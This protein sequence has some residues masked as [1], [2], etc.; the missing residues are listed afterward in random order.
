MEKFIHEDLFSAKGTA[1]DFMVSRDV[2]EAAYPN[3]FAEAAYYFNCGL[4]DTGTEQV[5]VYVWEDEDGQIYVGS[6]LANFA[7]YKR[8]QELKQSKSSIFH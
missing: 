4:S 2:L 6:E 3:E 5:I 8:V 7:C 1:E